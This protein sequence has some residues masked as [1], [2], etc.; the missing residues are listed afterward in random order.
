MLFTFMI[1]MLFFIA[2]F[3]CYMQ[4]VSYDISQIDW[5]WEGDEY[6]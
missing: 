1:L 2:L 5:T 4:K 3:G 6:L